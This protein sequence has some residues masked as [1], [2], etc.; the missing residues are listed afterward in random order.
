MRFGSNRIRTAYIRYLDEDG[1]IEAARE[2][3]LLL[4]LRFRPG[5]FVTQ[6]KTLLH[7]SPAERVTEKV[8]D[9]LRHTFVVGM[10][11]SRE[12]NL[13]FLFDQLVEVSMRAL[14][15]GINDPF[16]A[17]N[18]MDW[19]RAALRS[20]AE[21]D[22]AAA[23]RFDKEKNLRVVAEPLGFEAYAGMVFD[24]MRPYVAADRNA[25][26]HMME[27][28]AKL[29]VDAPKES[30]RRLLVR[31][32]TALLRHSRALQEEK[33]DLDLLRRRYKDLLKMLRDEDYRRELIREGTWIGGRA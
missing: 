25:S 7:A 18:C 30:Q 4:R 29:A 12:Q 21:R 5:D 17:M 32:A 6:G 13:Q 26:I 3:D 2:H 9:S 11:R 16:T 31:H 23:F 33:R 14:S 15:P 1:L 27:M 19:L 8:A 20:L 24:Q 28:L 22:P 10:Q